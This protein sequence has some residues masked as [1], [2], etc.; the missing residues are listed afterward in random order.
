MIKWLCGLIIKS[1]KPIEEQ[2]ADAQD[3]QWD[4]EYKLGWEFADHEWHSPVPRSIVKQMLI[5]QMREVETAY[6]IA[7][8]DF[9]NKYGKDV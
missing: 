6:E 4:Q 1:H 7:I 2:L 5:K 9:L 8:Y 3:R